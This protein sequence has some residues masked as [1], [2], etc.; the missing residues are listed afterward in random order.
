MQ[1]IRSTR[2]RRAL[3]KH[4]CAVRGACKYQARHAFRSSTVVS[5]VATV[6]SVDMM[7]L[8]KLPARA[9]DPVVSTL[10]PAE[11]QPVCSPEGSERQ[12]GRTGRSLLLEEVVIEVLAYV[13]VCSQ[14]AKR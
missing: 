11:C 1:S 2:M 10:H 3:F 6:V 14:V 8:S 7:S 12:R 9:S 5:G 4:Q 13:L